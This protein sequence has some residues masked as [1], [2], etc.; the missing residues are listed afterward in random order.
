MP[1]FK[2]LPKFAAVQ[3][4]TMTQFRANF[5]LGAV[6]QAIYTLL[7]V[8]FV[9]ALLPAGESLNGWS[10]WH[11]I[12]LFGFGDLAFGLSAIFMFRIFLG[13]EANYI[14]AGRLDQLLVQPLP[15]LTSLVLRN[16]DLNHLAVV[17]KG[18]ALVALASDHLDLD[19][20]LTAVVRIGVLAGCGAAVYAGLYLAF[21]SLGFWFRRR[22]SLALPVLSLN[23]LTQYPLSIYPT[24]LQ[25]VLTFVLPLGLATYYPVHALLQFHGAPGIVTIPF[26]LLPVISALVL[27]FGIRAFHMGLRSYV[28]SG[29]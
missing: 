5:L 18:A 21:V 29:T 22:S 1:F 28:G 4:K 19:W 15:V 25:A 8:V 11:V 24:P 7:G 2:L 3:L 9:D 17:L 23:Y 26:W 6:G 27:L 12:L 13:F 10:F 14:I 20:S 16:M